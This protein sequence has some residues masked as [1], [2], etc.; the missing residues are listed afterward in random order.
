[1]QNFGYM[2]FTFDSQNPIMKTKNK[3]LPF[4]TREYVYTNFLLT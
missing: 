4:Y 1:M 2:I 3:N